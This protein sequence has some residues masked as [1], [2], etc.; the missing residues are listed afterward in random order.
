MFEVVKQGFTYPVVLT[1]LV[2]ENCVFCTFL[3]HCT[4]LLVDINDYQ[5]EMLFTQLLY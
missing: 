5:S 2:K 3:M 4:V 1:L